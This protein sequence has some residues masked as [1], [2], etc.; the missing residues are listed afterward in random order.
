MMKKI[1][2]LLVVLVALLA[3]LAAQHQLPKLNYGYAALE[4]YVDSTTMFIH[5]NNHH[6]AYVNNLNTALN[7]YPELQKKSLAEIFRN[8]DEIPEDIRTSVRNNGGGHWNHTLF[9]ELLAPASQSKMTPFVQM[10]LVKDFGSVDKFKEEFAKASLSRFG[11]GWAWLIKDANGRLK[12]TSTA[13]QD[14]P[15]MSFIAPAE[16]GKPVLAID[17][18]EHAYY[19]KYQSKRAEYVKNFWS[20]VNWA[21]VEELL[22]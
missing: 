4:P 5:Y 7:K 18:W 6:Q 22:K 17:V 19:L 20:V 9:W 21:K 3:P 1:I 8:M 13:N 14:N 16:K 15:L 12:I 2:F 10:Q 11:S